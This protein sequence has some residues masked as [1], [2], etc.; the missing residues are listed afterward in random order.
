M[1]LTITNQA[2]NSITITNAGKQPDGGDI[3]WDAATFTWDNA[4]GT[5]DIPG[6]VIIR[7]SKNTITITN[8]AKN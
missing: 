5:W 1:A 2:K 6:L 8:Q 4:T 7:Q 3:T